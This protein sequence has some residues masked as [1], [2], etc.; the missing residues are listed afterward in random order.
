MKRH[1]S[2]LHE[3]INIWMLTMHSVAFGLFILG[4]V[5]FIVAYY[6]YLADVDEGENHPFLWAIDTIVPILSFIS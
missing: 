4:D 5:F 6:L 1:L 2:S 3:E